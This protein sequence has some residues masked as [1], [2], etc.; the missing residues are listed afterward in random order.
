MQ[1]FVGHLGAEENLTSRDAGGAHAF[2]DGALGA[3]FARGVDVAVAALQ[4]GGDVLGAN[5]A[6]A[7]RAKADGRNGGAVSRQR[8]GER[9][10]I[11]FG[12]RLYAQPRLS[13]AFFNP[14]VGLRK[15][16]S[17]VQPLGAVGAW[18]LPLARMT[19]LPAV[20]SPSSSTSE[21]SST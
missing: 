9:H 14:S 7:R 20:H 2:A 12:C 3:V 13:S 19:K 16:T 15:N 21:P 1:V 10:G 11:A 4:R 17:M 5:V 8:R 6:H 18:R